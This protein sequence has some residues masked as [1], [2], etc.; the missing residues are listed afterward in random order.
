MGASSLETTTEYSGEA[1]AHIKFR[2]HLQVDGKITRRQA[3][4]RQCVS[5]GYV[6]VQLGA[7]QCRLGATAAHARVAVALT[8][9]D[10]VA[11]DFKR[12][13]SLKAQSLIN[14]A[15]PERCDAQGSRGAA[16][17]GQRTSL[18]FTAIRPGT[19]ALLADAPGVCS[20]RQR[21][22]PYPGKS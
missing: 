5:S 19:P 14:D 15:E 10:Q 16:Q 1:Q 13:E 18:R 20:Q 22:S 3:K 12:Y 7:A 17:P 8:N 2:L 6:L 21:R 11:V 9:R 4:I